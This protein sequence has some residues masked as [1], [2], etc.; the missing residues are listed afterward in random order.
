VDV[1]SRAAF[2]LKISVLVVGANLI[3]AA[4]YLRERRHLPRR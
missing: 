3:G 1:V 4:L 2:A